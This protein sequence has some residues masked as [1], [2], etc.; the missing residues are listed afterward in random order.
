MFL[1]ARR[2]PQSP[3]D[4]HSS[5]YAATTLCELSSSLCVTLEM[6]LPA[7]SATLTG[8]RTAKFRA[9]VPR[10]ARRSL[11]GWLDERIFEA[12][13]NHDP[14]IRHQLPIVRTG[15]LRILSASAIFITVSSSRYGRKFFQLRSC[16]PHRS[17]QFSFATST[18]LAQNLL[19]NGIAGQIRNICRDTRQFSLPMIQRRHR[20]QG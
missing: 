20:T 16:S 6:G 7:V 4:H 10:R 1:L 14:N 19:S 18:L 8:Q 2:T 9:R 15:L 17:C 11:S 13:R 5:F 3:D 12:R